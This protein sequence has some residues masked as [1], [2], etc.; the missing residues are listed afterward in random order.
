MHTTA[1]SQDSLLDIPPHSIPPASSLVESRPI[2]VDS[3]ERTSRRILDS[4]PHV[5]RHVR[6][7]NVAPDRTCLVGV[8][9]EEA[10]VGGVEGRGV[11]YER[12]AGESRVGDGACCVVRGAIEGGEG[13]GAFDDVDFAS[14]W[15]AVVDDG[16]ECRPLQ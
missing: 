1:A 15:P 4:T 16:P 5:A 8:G 7:T 2:A 9:A 11:L 13:V 14:A 6:I 12:E 3:I 10:A